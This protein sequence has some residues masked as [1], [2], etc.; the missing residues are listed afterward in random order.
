MPPT[1]PS[2][3]IPFKNL[4][5]EEE[6]KARIENALATAGKRVALVNEIN[7]SEGQLSK[8]INGEVGRFCHLLGVMNLEIW[9]VGY[10]EGLERVLREKL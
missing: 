9:P 4:N 5:I 6:N 2:L 3:I 7:V 10:V 1:L 8:M